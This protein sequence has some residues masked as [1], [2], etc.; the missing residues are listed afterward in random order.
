MR[1]G[2]GSG[3]PSVRGT[4]ALVALPITLAC[5]ALVLQVCHDPSGPTTILLNV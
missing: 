1:R 5:F 2:P 4:Q 3:C